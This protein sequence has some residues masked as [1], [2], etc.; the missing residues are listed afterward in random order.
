MVRPRSL[1]PIFNLAIAASAQGPFPIY[2]I[3][4]A[5]SSTHKGY[6]S[7]PYHVPFT[8]IKNSNIYIA[9]TTQ[10]YLTCPDHLS[11]AC[12]SRRA[13]NYTTSKALNDT[14]KAAGATI[15][16]AAGIHPFQSSSGSNETT[17]DAVVTLHVQDNP[18]CNGL[19][20]W[21]VIVHAS[22]AHPADANAAK[23]PTSWTG[24]SLLIGSFATREDANY[25]GKY[26]RNPK[27]NQLWLVYSAQQS[28]Y[29]H[30]RDGVAAWP[31]DSPTTTV[32]GSNYTFLL[33]PHDDL[34]SEDYR[35]GNSSFK[36]IETGN[37]RV[38]N[39]TFVMAYSAGG[40]ARKT[41]KSGVA[42]SD[43]FLPSNNSGTHPK[44][45]RKVMK[46]NPHKLWGSKGEKEVWYMLQGDE[47]QDGWRYVGD[48]VLA[49]GVPTVAQIGGSDGKGWVLMFAGYDASDKEHEYEAKYRRP[50]YI[51]LQVDVPEDASVKGASD[52]EI[53]GWIVPAH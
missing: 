25:D 30:K 28:G 44:Q 47:N 4:K 6:F 49:P 22:P 41:Y 17:W 51:D 34:G 32:K 18:H 31:L 13:N 33:V 9:G 39:G 35:S 37:I 11:P 29:P 38:I 40:F 24:D 20:G 36:L 19:S 16:S 12:A 23:P 21:S 48:R 53:R 15:C 52:Q 26:F 8:D 46:E 50:Y 45:Y 42:F 5:N 14:A 10:A 43:T 7:D 3:T 27:D 2:P 1:W